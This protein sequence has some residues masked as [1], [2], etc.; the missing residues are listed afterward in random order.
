MDADEFCTNIITLKLTALNKSYPY[1]T[2][3]G[4]YCKSHFTKS[5]SV[6]YQDCVVPFMEF[7]VQTGDFICDGG[8]DKFKS[9]YKWFTSVEVTEYNP[10][11]KQLTLTGGCITADVI[12]KLSIMYNLILNNVL[13]DYNNETL[14]EITSTYISA[15]YPTVHVNEIQLLPQV[16]L[17]E[18]CQC[19][20]RRW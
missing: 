10:H 4:H 1:N 9:A 6:L 14:H 13:I 7:Q 12:S 8:D 18:L 11:I 20:F 19:D 17:S 3:D 5:I 15:Q 16:N 2:A